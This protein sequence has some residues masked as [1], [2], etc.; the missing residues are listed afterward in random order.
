MNVGPE[1]DAITH[2]IW[3]YGKAGQT[4]T[5]PTGVEPVTFGSGGRRSVQLSY[6]N[7]KLEFS[8]NQSRIEHREHLPGC[9]YVTISYAVWDS[10]SRIR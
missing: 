10:L 5:F 2:K 9:S 3:V 6:G 4:L 1:E 7:G 8:V